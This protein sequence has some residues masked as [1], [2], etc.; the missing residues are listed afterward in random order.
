M[1]EDNGNGCFLNESK[2]MNFHLFKMRT[3]KIADHCCRFLSILLMVY[4]H[5]SA[6]AFLIVINDM[7]QPIANWF[8]FFLCNAGMAFVYVNYYL[9][10]TIDPGFVPANFH[11]PLLPVCQSCGHYKPP[12]THHCSVCDRCVLVMD[13]HCPWVGGCIGYFNLPFFLRFLF[14]VLITSVVLFS[15]NFNLL[16][17][18]S[19]PMLNSSSSMFSFSR[20]FASEASTFVYGSPYVFSAFSYALRPVLISLLFKEIY[21][22]QMIL[23]SNCI[24]LGIV[25]FSVL[26]LFVRQMINLVHGRTYI[27]GLEQETLSEYISY[28]IQNQVSRWD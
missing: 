3:S 22:R 19:Y 27:E 6:L 9:T 17:C 4:L 20:P 18:L 5:L 15:L 23:L 7:S 11:H 16:R 13:H 26:I 24:I 10:S 8:Y 1:T 28:M 21:K 25:F 12:R 14:F 2:M